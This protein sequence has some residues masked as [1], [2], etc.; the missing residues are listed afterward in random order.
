[1]S[2]EECARWLQKINQKGLV[3]NESTKQFVKSVIS[4]QEKAFQEMLDGIPVKE[5]E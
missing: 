3:C 1:M 5:E 2:N 4:E